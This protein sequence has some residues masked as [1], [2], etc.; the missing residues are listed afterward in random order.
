MALKQWLSLVALA[1]TSLLP[2]L[3][4]ANTLY[5]AWQGSGGQ[6][7]SSPSNRVF[8]LDAP[9]TGTPV[10]FT[11]TSS[12]DAWLYLLDANGTVLAQDDNSGGGTNAR[13]SLTLPAGSFKVVAA[14]ALSNQ[15][16]EFSLSA[17]SL[18]LRY[19]KAL[20]LKPWSRFTWVYDD[21][22]TGATNDISV[23][24]PDLSLTP[25]FFSLG[26]V[27]MPDR[28]QAPATT[29]LVRGEGDLLARPSNY[30]WIWSDSGSGGTHDVSF[31]EPVAP[32]GYTCL[33]H[34]AVL[35][36][37]KPST[38]LIRCVRSEYVLPANP[39]WLWDDSGSGANDDIGVWQATARDHR[40]LPASTFV[41]RP[42]HG[43]TGGN[44]YWALNKSATS[45]AELRG[46]P[47]DAQT[48]AAFAP[49]I[50]LHPDESYFPSSTQFHL[51]NV[52]EENGH[53]VTNQALGCDS[54]TD[55][56]F[57]DG[58][59]PNQTP[60]PV[61]AQRI[62]RT[63][64]G[65]P[66]NVTDVLYWS[67]YPY[68]NGKRVCI[69]WYSPWGCVGGYSTFGNHVGDWEHL[70]VRFIDGRP[71]RVYL[72]Q[73]ANGQDFPFG[74]KAVFFTGWHPEVFSARGSHGLYPDAARHIYETIFNGDFLADDTGAGLAWDTWNSLVVIPWQPA[75]SYTGSLAWMNLTAYWGNPEGGCDNP[76]GYCVN[77]G[78]PSPLRN[79]SVYQPE[80]MTLE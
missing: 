60:V 33:G 49:R 69:G 4:W 15:S 22:G 27:A 76:T 70:T 41:S 19:P 53:L 74:D 37:S 71:A 50:W 43:D 24:R 35:G 9:S 79:R 12:A 8:L 66:T 57:L 3:A 63:Q 21:H 17:D 23:W 7:P 55:P 45:N 11:L 65:Q 42:S 59:R 61:Y 62:A 64:G 56:Q 5:G 48:V 30:T 77:S 51:A 58:Q 47:V 6:S 18:P 67:F 1:T 54:C 29:F 78:G 39:A 72:S 16:A 14:T 13:L 46:Q 25:G 80:Y 32:A 26:D 31:W 73:H 44:R 2:D 75:G 34:V 10:V 52:H 38:D 36:Y 20:E 40:A 68:N 28:G